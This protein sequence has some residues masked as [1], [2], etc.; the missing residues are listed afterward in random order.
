MECRDIEQETTKNMKRTKIT[1]M[2]TNLTVKDKQTRSLINKEF[3]RRFCARTQT[4]GK[5]TSLSVNKIEHRSD[6]PPTMTG[7]D[8]IESF[9]FCETAPRNLARAMVLIKFRLI[10]SMP[11]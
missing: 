11:T 3:F 7:P 6:K 4:A 10:D 1:N 8:W 9:C 5:T 2:L